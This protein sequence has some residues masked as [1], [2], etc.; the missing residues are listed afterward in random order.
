MQDIS[1][2]VMGHSSLHLAVGWPA[3]LGLLV[4][5]F[6]H[7]VNLPSSCGE[8]PIHYACY[9]NCPESVRILLDNNTHLDGAEGDAFLY[10]IKSENE[11]IVDMLIESM[12]NRR[13]KLRE[14]AQLY[15]SPEKFAMIKTDRVPDADVPFILQELETLSVPVPEAIN[16]G[17]LSRVW[18]T[19]YHAL[20]SICKP[21]L[22]AVAERL[23]RAGF[24]DVDHPNKK[25]NTPLMEGPHPYAF[26][27]GIEDADLARWLISRGAE[28]LKLPHDASDSAQRAGAIPMQ[29]VADR[30]GTAMLKCLTTRDQNRSFSTEMF[31][32]KSSVSYILRAIA[33]H[34]I[35]DK[36]TCPC[37]PTG[38]GCTPMTVF[39]RN[40]RG[41]SGAKAPA[42][43]LFFLAWLSPRLTRIF[44]RV[45]GTE[46][47]ADAVAER[48][49]YMKSIVRFLTFEALH[50][51][52]ICCLSNSRRDIFSDPE[53][54]FSCRTDEEIAAIINKDGQRQRDDLVEAIYQECKSVMAGRDEPLYSMLSAHWAPLI[55]A[56][57]SQLNEA[58]N[59]PVMSSPE[60]RPE[61][62]DTDDDIYEDAV[63]QIAEDGSAEDQHIVEEVELDED[64]QSES[65]VDIFGDT[66][67]GVSEDH[68]ESN[69]LADDL[70]EKFWEMANE[71][72]D[73]NS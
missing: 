31:D 66:S 58:G 42:R 59:S 68:E 45:E 18:G 26:F 14:L 64:E 43:L 12:A 37:S 25:G 65:T 13:L 60:L 2:D 69:W 50:V 10:A 48:W 73:E 39:L 28:T 71:S 24:L 54:S 16:P 34:P 5:A 63:E 52:H 57:L 55:R 23:Y 44:G 56:V 19:V 41:D 70:F 3:G 21:W 51:E 15:L 30:M 38:W 7:L 49:S 27:S 29:Y 6:P 32:E 4:D 9:T 22:P 35:S 72:I 53:C 33:L 40:L 67:D 46:N 36:C 1:L 61:Q 17:G 11:K 8:L 62:D 47:H 20:Y